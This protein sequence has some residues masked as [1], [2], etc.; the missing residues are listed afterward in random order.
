MSKKLFVASSMSEGFRGEV[1]DVIERLNKYLSLSSLP[2]FDSYVYGENRSSNGTSDTQSEINKNIEESDLFIMVVRSGRPIG[3]ISYQ[4]YC[5]AHQKSLQDIASG[6]TTPLHI[7]VFCIVNEGDP[8]QLTVA[9][10]ESKGSFESILYND[11][12]RYIDF[13]K[14]KPG[15]NQ[16]KV[17]GDK[18]EHCLF[19]FA[20]NNR[21]LHQ[22]ELSYEG[23]VRPNDQRFRKS[24]SKYF[25]R[26]DL[27]GRIDE[28]INGLGSSLVILE[29][30]TYSGKTMAAYNIMSTNE[31]WS[32]HLFYIYNDKS[33]L[34]ALEAL[35]IKSHSIDDSSIGI[36]IDNSHKR[37]I[38]IDDINNLIAED[39]TLNRE[40][41]N[42]IWQALSRL[43]DD[44]PKFENTTIIIT[45]SGRL[46]HAEKIALESKIFGKEAVLHLKSSDGILPQISVNFDIYNIASFKKMVSQLRAEGLDAKSI[47]PGNYTIGSLFLD[48][49]DIIRAVQ[50]IISTDTDSSCRYLFHTLK[51][52]FMFEYNHTGV[53]SHIYKL[54]RYICQIRGG[55]G[56]VSYDNMLTHALDRLRSQGLILYDNNTNN[57][58][59]KVI[60]V[61][62]FILENMP[63][64]DQSEK[65]KRAFDDILGYAKSIGE[66]AETGYKLINKG[67]CTKSEIH[68]IVVEVNFL[69]NGV[70]YKAKKESKSEFLESYSNMLI[71]IYKSG[72][73]DFNTH[74]FCSVAIVRIDSFEMI[75]SILDIL[76]SSCI[77]LFKDAMYWLINERLELPLADQ[78]RVLAKI[79]GDYDGDGILDL[80][81]PFKIEDCRQAHICRRLMHHLPY[82]V[83]NM[84]E[85]ANSIEL[86]D[87]EE[88]FS[89]D[90]E[91]EEGSSNEDSSNNIFYYRNVQ[92]VLLII[93]GKSNSIQ[94]LERAI[95]LISQSHLKDKI[96]DN[97]IISLYYKTRAIAQNFNYQ[98]RSTLFKFLLNVESPQGLFKISE[99]ISNEDTIQVSLPDSDLSE[100][101]IRALN[102]ILDL[103]DDDSALSCFD[104]MIKADRYDGYTLSF[105]TKNNFLEFEY[106]Y[107][108]FQRN[109]VEDRARPDKR[110]IVHLISLNQLFDKVK[111]VTDAQVCLN[112]LVDKGYIEKGLPQYIRDEH[113]LASYIG[114][115]YVSVEETISL[116]KLFNIELRIKGKRSLASTT[117]GLLTYKLTFAQL[118]DLL[119]GE[120]GNESFF[121]KWGLTKAERELMRDNPVTYNHWI[122][123]VSN[124]KEAAITMEHY[125]EM[126]NDPKISKLIVDDAFNN[127]TAIISAILRSGYLFSSFDDV[128]EFINKLASKHREFKYTRYIY[129]NLLHWI[130]QDACREKGIEENA[131]SKEAITLN[132]MKKMNKILLEAYNYFIKY[133][134][135]SQVVTTMSEL[136]QYPMRLITQDMFNKEC[137]YILEEKIYNC[138]LIEYITKIESVNCKYI[139]KTFVY[140][141]LLSM[142]KEY[143]KEVFMVLKRITHLNRQGITLEAT[144]KLNVRKLL[145]TW[146]QK[147]SGEIDISIDRDFIPTYSPIK[148]I[149]WL[150]SNKKIKYDDAKR[151]LEA[152]PNI[153]VTQTYIN[154]AFKSIRRDCNREAY[155]NMIE[156]LDKYYNSNNASNS[157][158][159]KS[160][161]MLIPLLE[162][163]SRPEDF[164]EI[165]N[166]FPK[167]L[168]N[169][170]EVL[171]VRIRKIFN[172]TLED[173]PYGYDPMLYSAS[174]LI[175]ENCDWVNTYNI[176]A[177]INLMVRKLLAPGAKGHLEVDP[178]ILAELQIKMRS[179]WDMILE[180]RDINLATLLHMPEEELERVAHIDIKPNI[181]SY[182]YFMCIKT[183]R[184]R[185]HPFEIIC[186]VS[187][188]DFSYGNNKNCLKDCLVNCNKFSNDWTR[189]QEFL[190]L[191][192]N[193][194]IKCQVEDIYNNAGYLSKD[195]FFMRFMG[196]ILR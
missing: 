126:I 156:L 21:A 68:H 122:L 60:F 43:G 54:Y 2:T 6:V 183:P 15:D 167:E 124:N 123:K 177:Y 171:D 149:W 30:S 5:V 108:I 128:R 154:M 150:L 99:I 56:S 134:N 105:L 162:T 22:N 52:H 127:K 102:N 190:S 41:T 125:N 98:D 137:E 129:G 109:I 191:E 47:K 182:T 3:N 10:E 82:S 140:N 16:T 64:L 67:N 63:L 88:V 50:E 169:L 89:F 69:T 106:L 145:L 4:E 57:T 107:N 188:G 113:T 48:N 131:D 61:D 153:Q 179:C 174:K 173:V 35:N 66:I 86:Y 31:A 120:Y 116:F 181:Q 45:I 142:K 168:H 39:T 121:Q 110:D 24:S 143:D 144:S 33:H 87:S 37:V 74:N 163:A 103:L 36:S 159:Y 20:N 95:N 189:M 152:N 196:I 166:Q 139:G 97:F 186:K 62:K 104:A 133:S 75:M 32:D 117:I 192:E 7:K 172:N 170:V 34:S 46:S 40:N 85:L 44:V 19:E 65:K 28:I 70:V 135:Y 12:K 165:L 49:N 91:D 148:L 58:D 78:K 84:M 71:Q 93:I 180:G 38:L 11:S 132:A 138:K 176:N 175:M 96:D 112:L 26:Q 77:E 193:Y 1:C 114:I 115:K 17:I 76:N 100:N 194:N 94:E 146:N 184:T 18:I 8:I 178:L 161:Q 157:A 42:G 83:D 29:G 195:K 101:H 185:P 55:S 164:K 160:V 90:D 141:L 111:N 27:D 9:G 130:Y 158:L 53:Y 81:Y 155:S 151:Y 118:T 13:I 14:I 187:G 25:Y 147:P 59:D 80:L 72:L 79:I 73:D 136:Y 119:Y 92:A 51:C 23:N